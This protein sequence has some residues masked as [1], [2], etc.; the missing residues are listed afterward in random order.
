V[1]EEI[2]LKPYILA[3]LRSWHVVILAGVLVG[4][5]SGLIRFLT[6]PQYE[7]R[8]DLLILSSLPE[9][10]MMALETI[11][12]SLNIEERVAELLRKQNALPVNYEL[13]MLTDRIQVETNGNLIQ[14][15]STANTQTEAEQLV[16][17]WTKQLVILTTSLV[18][19]DQT[20]IAIT[21]QQIA[22]AKERY[23]Q[24]QANLESF[25]AS[26]ELI[27]AN[28]EVR[29]LNDLIESTRSVPFARLNEYLARRNE[30]ELILRDARL[31]RDRLTTEQGN[32]IADATAA[33][34]LRIRNLSTR[35]SQPI[36]QLDSSVATAA[37]VSIE[38]LN[39]LITSLERE[40]QAV[41]NSI[42]QLR[43]ETDVS[44]LQDLISQLTAA[45]LR[46]EQLTARQ[47]ELVSERD[48]AYAQLVSLQQRLKDLK[49]IAPSSFL[50]PTS[51]NP[52]VYRAPRLRP[53]ILYTAIGNL[54]GIVLAATIIIAREALITARRGTVLQPK[55]T[56]D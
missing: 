1:E 20:A 12:G 37:R 18:V 15:F 13:G 35:G 29:R 36:L 23:Q 14:I 33:L 46:V 47:R 41:S 6:I 52:I 8:Q 55:P 3:L 19:Q 51:N 26:D 31:L 16:N 9:E 38:D 53:V 25:L 45:Q 5:G 49:A 42:D 32:N 43:A 21:E 56:G 10:Q 40:Y 30:I 44:T 17:L 39:R 48:K 7:A 28:Q 34:L 27:I 22:E 54:A 24:A 4:L 11:A 50:R 2:D